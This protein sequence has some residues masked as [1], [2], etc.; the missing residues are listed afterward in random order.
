MRSRTSP[1]ATPRAPE[2][3]SLA[4]LAA[5]AAFAPQPGTT[6][7]GPAEAAPAV[8]VKRRKALPADAAA[9]A[10]PPR[11][12]GNDAA[13]GGGDHVPRTYRVRPAREAPPAA[14]PPDATA[15]AG[16]ASPR[17][18]R[19]RAPAAHRPSDVTIIRPASA[20]AADAAPDLSR[21]AMPELVQRLALITAD[22]RKLEHEALEAKRAESA[23]A[24]RWIKRA[25]AEYGLTAAD[26]G[27]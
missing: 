12:P 14:A 22:I 26:L 13:P 18:R 3:A 23:R 6:A 4:R 24:V 1:A 11:H 17:A 2:P 9:P 8:I 5:E 10:Q 7:T 15:P 21:A 25:I 27:Y 19:R 16:G 20:E